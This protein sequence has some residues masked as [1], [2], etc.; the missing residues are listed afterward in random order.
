MSYTE[1]EKQPVDWVERIITFMSLK[2]QIENAKA[3]RERQR[4]K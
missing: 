3:E 1:L 4:N 2:N